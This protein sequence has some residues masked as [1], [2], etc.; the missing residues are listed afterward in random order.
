[1]LLA[2]RHYLRSLPKGVRLTRTPEDLAM[3]NCVV[4]TEIET[5]NTWSVCPV[6]RF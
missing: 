5:R 6:S 2:H 1:M 4:Y 3:H